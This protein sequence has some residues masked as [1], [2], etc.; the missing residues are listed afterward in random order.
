MKASDWR[1]QVIGDGTGHRAMGVKVG[2]LRSGMVF[3][4]GA[5]KS[6]ERPAGVRAAIVAT[7]RR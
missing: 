6:R 3:M 2:D 7:K 1:H 4:R 5:P